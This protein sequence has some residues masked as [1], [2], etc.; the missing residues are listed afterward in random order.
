MQL[1][2]PTWAQM[3]ES[4]TLNIEKHPFLFMWTS[5]LLSL[6]VSSHSVFTEQKHQ[7]QA[8][9]LFLLFINIMTKDE[10]HHS[11]SWSRK[12]SLESVETII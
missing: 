5:W 9:A 4:V 7:T 10:A 8:V 1:Q 3:K 12:A 2:L 6:P 11:L